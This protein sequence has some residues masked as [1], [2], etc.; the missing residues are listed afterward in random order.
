MR[1]GAERSVQ[2]N[3][4]Y[5]D[6][7]E[8]EEYTAYEQTAGLEREMEKFK[9]RLSAEAGR[10]IEE[11]RQKRHQSASKRS[12]VYREVLSQSHEIA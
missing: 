11:G 10:M 3:R 7:L 2:M 5:D 1:G 6:P 9:A 8:G 4:K 12:S